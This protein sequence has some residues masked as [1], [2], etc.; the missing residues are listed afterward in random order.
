M[1]A[2]S[3]ETRRKRLI[4][5]SWRRGFRELDLVLGAF[6]DQRLAELDEAE[7][8][9]YEALLEVPDQHLYAWIVGREPTPAE[10]DGRVME[11]LRR[12]DYLR[13]GS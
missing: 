6:A 12:L 9:E 1:P 4:F 11:R 8:S 7:L 13:Q 2:L 10:C 5:R 3:L